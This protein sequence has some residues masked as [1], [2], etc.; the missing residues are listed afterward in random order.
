MPDP[1]PHEGLPDQ[2]LRWPAE[3]AFSL[4]P[5]PG[6]GDRGDRT[7]AVL[8]HLSVVPLL[9]PL[10]VALGRGPR[11]PYVTNQA[12]EALN[13]QITVGLAVLVCSLLTAVLIGLL[14]LPVIAVT[15]A[16]LAVRAASA[17]RRGAWYRYPMTLRFLT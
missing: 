16:T 8:T 1:M 3:W 13:F 5:P 4:E 15:A 2:P 14:L 12:L 7:W 17:A 9:V 11:S 6:H 10:A